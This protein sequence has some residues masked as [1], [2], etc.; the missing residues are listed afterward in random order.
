[1][2]NKKGYIW[3]EKKV[4]LEKKKKKEKRKTKIEKKKKGKRSLSVN[5]DFTKSPTVP[6]VSPV[7]KHYNL[8]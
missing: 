4:E 1:M 7:F 5:S 2:E 3:K 6:G 8:I